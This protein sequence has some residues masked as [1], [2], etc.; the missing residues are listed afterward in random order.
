MMPGAAQSLDAT[1][2]WGFKFRGRE[3]EIEGPGD[4]MYLAGDRGTA[5]A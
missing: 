3:A 4:W 5:W 1:D 2:H